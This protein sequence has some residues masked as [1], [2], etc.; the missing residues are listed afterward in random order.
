M[1]LKAIGLECFDFSMI[2]IDTAMAA[3]DAM[4]HSNN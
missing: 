4:N 2:A 1:E 3:C